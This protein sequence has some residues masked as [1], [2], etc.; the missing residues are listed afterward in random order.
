FEVIVLE[1]AGSA[2]ELNLKSRD[3]T[4]LGLA[5]RLGIPVLLV[6]DIDRGG[7]F[8]SIVGTFVLL[9]P[10]EAG[11]VRSFAINRFRGDASLF[12]DGRKILEERTGRPC[13]G[14]FPYLEDVTIDAEDS[15]SLEGVTPQRGSLRM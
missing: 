13:L 1:G 8:A 10:A 5:T 4:N 7:V 2:V 3:L 15:V 6:A 14:V 11:L 12:D 9:D